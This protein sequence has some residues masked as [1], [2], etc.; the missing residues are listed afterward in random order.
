MSYGAVLARSCLEKKKRCPVCGAE[1]EINKEGK[2]KC[3]L[4]GHILPKEEKIKKATI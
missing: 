3:P 1:M 4:C 2:H